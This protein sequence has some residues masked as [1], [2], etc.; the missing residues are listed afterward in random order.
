M[1]VQSRIRRGEALRPSAARL[2]ATASLLLD[3]G[4]STRRTLT[5]TEEIG[6]LILSILLTPVPALAVAWTWRDA[7]AA[8]QALRVSIIALVINVAV[9]WS[10]AFL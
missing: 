8:G 3:E 1:E 9:G 5:R 4:E 7:P 10:A 6:L 2:Q